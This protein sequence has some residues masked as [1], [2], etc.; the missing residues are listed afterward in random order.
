MLWP[1]IGPR[2]QGSRRRAGVALV[3]PSTQRRIELFPRSPRSGS[4]CSFPS[5]N[6]L[7]FSNS[8]ISADHSAIHL[9]NRP[10]CSSVMVL[11]YGSA[12]TSPIGQSTQRQRRSNAGTGALR[13]IQKPANTAN[14]SS[15]R[16]VIGIDF[17]F[18]H[19]LELPTAYLGSHSSP[20]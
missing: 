2:Q 12:I 5:T 4:S 15:F 16:A 14:T 8:H 6:S 17:C 11:Q 3:A 1:L 20:R 18:P 10:A 9:L 7:L 13:D 19:W